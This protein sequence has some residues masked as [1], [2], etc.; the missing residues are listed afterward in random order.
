MKVT[1]EWCQVDDCPAKVC[2]GPHVQHKHEW[3]N[4]PATFTGRVGEECFICHQKF[5]EEA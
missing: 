4:G 1:V 3:H 2:G 5:E